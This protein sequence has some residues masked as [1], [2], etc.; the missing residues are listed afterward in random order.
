MRETKDQTPQ[1]E[2]CATRT[3]TMLIVLYPIA[4]I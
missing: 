4:M 3:H 1:A 2:A